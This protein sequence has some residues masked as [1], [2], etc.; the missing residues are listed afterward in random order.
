MS[1]TLTDDDFLPPA[2]I[3]L[4]AVILL[5]PPVAASCCFSKP[6]A[7][8]AVVR[9]ELGLLGL[10]KWLISS[11][12]EEDEM[13]PAAW[14]S[15]FRDGCCSSWVVIG[16]AEGDPAGD[17]T[18]AGGLEVDPDDVVS[19]Y[20]VAAAVDGL[21]LLLLLLL[22]VV[23]VVEV[24]S[25]DNKHDDDADADDGDDDVVDDDDDDCVILAGGV[26]S[27]GD[28]DITDC[29]DVNIL[30]QLILTRLRGGPIGGICWVA[31]ARN[32]S[33]IRCGCVV[34]MFFQP[35][36]SITSVA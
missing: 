27:D 7:E 21:L 22:V 10:V 28:V 3:R 18:T 11:D 4:A 35:T 14:P 6:P 9:W 2:L 34:T 17:G 19:W 32:A 25:D 15:S 16:A 30:F 29:T 26:G 5:S 36:V 23:L 1:F 24:D 20:R 13:W 33:F 12:D 31:R 8:A